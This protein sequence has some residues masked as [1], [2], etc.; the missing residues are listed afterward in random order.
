MGVNVAI[1]YTGPQKA[2]ILLLAFGEEISAEIF[3]H[4]T[5]FEI[6]R[7]G[8][9]MS[10]LG[11]VDSDAID[12]VMEE[13]Y[14]I[15]QSNKKYFLGSNDFTKRLIESAFKSDQASALID[16]L[17]LTSNA[18]LES[19]ELIDPKTLANFLRAEHPQT[20]ALILAHL[21]PKKF[22]ECLKILP[23][24]LHTELILR[25]ASLESV[26]PEIIDEIDDVL[27]NEIQRLGNVT[28][29]KVGGIDPIV[30]MLNLMDKA[31]EENILDRLEERDPD[32]AENIRKLM[33]V[34]DDLVKID[35]RGIQTVLREVKP[36]QLK[37]ALKTASEGVKELIYKNMS[38][39]AAENLKEEM[40]IA[41]PAKISDVEQAQFAIVQ[42]ARRLNDEG[43]IVISASGENALV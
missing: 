18:N 42:I 29:S 38:Q 1:K 15:L 20:M 8:S 41:G 22:G 28:S 9:A 12:A 5:E 35:D 17:S 34:F 25:V 32:L 10:R 37:L 14:Q 31:T 11:R 30:E 33:F 7:I 26:S 40:A 21:D 3:K 27:R 19:L 4:M 43:K 39:K 16:E 6:K 2:A 36:E 13:F 23:E 24:S